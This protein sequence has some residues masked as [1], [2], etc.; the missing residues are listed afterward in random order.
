MNIGLL[1]KK[2]MFLLGPYVERGEFYSVRSRPGPRRSG[3]DRQEQRKDK[4]NLKN[5]NHALTKKT[6][7]QIINDA[8]TDYASGIKS[9]IERTI[10]LAFER[11]AAECAHQRKCK[12][13]FL[14]E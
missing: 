2:F 3:A 13:L 9:D 7:A 12:R 1:I 6:V 4:T 8:A 11:I 14:L 5:S 10:D